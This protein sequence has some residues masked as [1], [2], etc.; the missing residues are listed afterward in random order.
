M[1]GNAATQAASRRLRV[2][3]ITKS[4]A[5]LATG[6]TATSLGEEVRKRAGRRSWRAAAAFLCAMRDGDQTAVEIGAFNAV[7]QRKEFFCEEHGGVEG[8]SRCS[9][10]QCT[11]TGGL[12][13]VSAGRTGPRRCCEGAQKAT[14]A[15]AC[16]FRTLQAVDAIR[17]WP[18]STDAVYRVS[19]ICLPGRW[20][21]TDDSVPS[22]RYSIRATSSRCQIDLYHPRI[23]CSGT[24]ASGPKL[25]E[26]AAALASSLRALPC[27][28]NRRLLKTSPSSNPRPV[29]QINS[30]HLTA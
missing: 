21:V 5:T 25:P 8:R 12:A 14:S 18:G 29:S 20:T 23:L 9:V 28:S 1:Q 22:G 24:W 6:N 7:G 10:T 26:A 13:A 27:T 17:G 11:P 4:P 19:R 2:L 16:M 3:R 30:L 15:G